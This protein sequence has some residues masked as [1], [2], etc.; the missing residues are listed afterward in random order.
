[1]AS[2][3]E[4][5]DV[6]NQHFVCIEFDPT[7][8]G[9]PVDEYPGLWRIGASWEHNPWTRVS[10]GAVWVIEPEGQFMLSPVTDDVHNACSKSRLV[11]LANHLEGALAKLAEIRS[12]PRGSEAEAEAIRQVAEQASEQWR[13]KSD[14]YLDARTKQIFVAAQDQNRRYPGVFK[15]PDPWVRLR[16][17]EL[18]SRYSRIE[19]DR[20]FLP[21]GEWSTFGENIAFCLDDADADVRTAAASALFEFAGMPVPSAE[22]DELVAAARDSWSRHRTAAAAN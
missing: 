13:M 19:G 1:M 21:G 16:A 10:F 9:V 12:H 4:V 15:N 17:I 20:G 3:K 8:I 22:G 7:G 5:Q 11:D 14:A 2:L 6:L 18:V